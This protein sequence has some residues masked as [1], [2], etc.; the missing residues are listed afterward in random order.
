MSEYSKIGVREIVW[1]PAY[2]VE[3]ITGEAKYSADIKLPRML[4][5][6]IFRSSLPHARVLNINTERAR[7]L[8]GVKAVVTAKDAPTLRYGVL[9]KDET[10]FATDKVR[11]IGAPVAAVAAVDELTALEALSLIEV[12][13]EELPP[14]FDGFS[15]MQPGATILNP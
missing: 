1:S 4:I 9:I 11:Y 8:K 5:G 10:I 7:N 6:K 15:A 12:E 13:Y 14:V 2:L 3:K